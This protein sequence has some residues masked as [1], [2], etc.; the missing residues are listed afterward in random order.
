MTATKLVRDIAAFASDSMRL[1]D[2]DTV[3]NAEQSQRIGYSETKAASCR[4]R[5]LRSIPRR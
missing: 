2:I 4:R 3:V 1:A 5:T